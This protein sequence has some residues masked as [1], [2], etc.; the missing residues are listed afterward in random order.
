V[1]STTRL[2]PLPTLDKP[3]ETNMSSTN[4]Y[5]PYTYLIGWSEHQKYYYGVRYAKGCEPNDLWVSYYTSSDHVKLFREEYGE[6]DI[7]QVRK[8]FDDNIKAREWEIKVLK[9]MNLP[10][11]KDF[12][13]IGIFNKIYN[14]VHPMLGKNHSEE[15]KQKMSNTHMGKKFSVESRER[16][17]QAN[18]GKK[19]SKE[20]RLKMSKRTGKKNPFYGKTHSEKL[21]KHLSE[22]I[23]YTTCIKCKKT[24]TNPL[25]YRWHNH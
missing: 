6:P 17:R 12:L 9:R 3:K 14:G 22:I 1:K 24:M 5:I 4:I 15:T 10:K 25:Y 7:I 2:P 16:M 13:N 23:G 18:L 11:R 19:I 20:T 21:K 8:T